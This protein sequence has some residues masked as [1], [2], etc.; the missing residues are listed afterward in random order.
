MANSHSLEAN[1][2]SLM[3]HI[4]QP[5]K[6]SLVVKLFIGLSFSEPRLGAQKLLDDTLDCLDQKNGSYIDLKKMLWV[7]AT[8]PVGSTIDFTELIF[9]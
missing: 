5:L 1:D 4:Y 3:D 6:F 2:Y 7:A 8:S 9:P